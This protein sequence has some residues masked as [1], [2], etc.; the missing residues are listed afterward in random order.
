MNAP[1]LPLEQMREAAEKRAI[2][3]VDVGW[4]VCTWDYETE[5]WGR[6][7]AWQDLTGEQTGKKYRRLFTREPDGKQGWVHTLA[8]EPVLCLTK[9]DAAKL[10]L[11]QEIRDIQAGAR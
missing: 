9:A 2:S 4:W 1:A 8:H 7:T 5:I 10:G 6:V 11:R 3:R